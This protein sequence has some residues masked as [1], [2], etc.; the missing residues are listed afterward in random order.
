MVR[1]R[2]IITGALMSAFLAFF[3]TYC[4]M[5][6]IRGSLAN[7]YMPAGAILMLFILIFVNLLLKKLKIEFKPAEL[8][9]IYGMMV[10]SGISLIDFF[11]H[12]IFMVVAPFYFA[13][14][15]NQY[16]QIQGFIPKWLIPKNPESLTSFYEGLPSG[17]AVPYGEW[18]GP[19]FFMSLMFIGIMLM[20]FCLSVIIRR[21]WIDNERLVFPLT[22]VPIEMVK[23]ESGGSGIPPFFKNKIM[24]IFFFIPVAVYAINNLNAWFPS[25]PVIPSAF[26]IQ[27]LFTEK[28][29]SA[30]ESINGGKI[31]YCII[32]FAYL[33][34]ASLSF[35]MWFFYVFFQIQTLIGTVCGFQMPIFQGYGQ[36]AFHVYQGA[37]ATVA[38]AGLLVWLMRG[39]LKQVLAKVFKNDPSVDDS[40]EGLPYKV[41][42]WGLVA[43]ILLICFWGM[44]AGISFWKV[45]IWLF[46]FAC[47]IIVL[48]RMVSEGG[49]YLVIFGF[50]PIDLIFPFAGS[51][52]LG[53]SMPMLFLANNMYAFNI[54]QCFATFSLGNFKIA[55][56]LKI[57]RR[58][59]SFAMILSLVICLFVVGL[60]VLNLS[61]HR[62]A[63]NLQWFF[64]NFFPNQ[65]TNNRI[66]R[67]MSTPEP[68]SLKDVFTM[69][70]GGGVVL[71]LFFMMRMFVKWPF[72]P[73]GYIIGA[74]A[75]MRALW[76]CTLLGWFIKVVTVRV[77][78]IKVHEHLKIGFAGLILGEFVSW[79]FWPIVSI[80]VRLLGQ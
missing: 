10:V 59:M 74:T 11:S 2:A 69:A 48:T 68:A 72:H 75:I 37:G 66:V 9:L 26:S 16:A 46:F 34:P 78:G 32:G 47:I 15:A 76:F 71:F 80:L 62:G 22:Y 21:Q 24:W 6:P 18:V 7:T 44:A 1:L 49:L 25:L 65:S 40:Q 3:I 58:K 13:N 57:N 8:M 28:P 20:M 50:Q 56:S 70:T 51:A 77:F 79:G 38:F 64:T 23:D 27:G 33:I 35:S 19:L 53:A 12:A 36:K 61:Y 42:F 52:I 41:A 39:H 54:Q 73:L 55:D 67:Y 30:L 29:W 17:T 43:G 45:F 4:E 14:S 60:T 5:L 31:Y 63:A